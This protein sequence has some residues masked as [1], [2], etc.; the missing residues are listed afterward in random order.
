MEKDKKDKKPAWEP[1][2][3]VEE[4]LAYDAEQKKAGLKK[5]K[6][7]IGNGKYAIRYM[8]AHYKIRSDE[9]EVEI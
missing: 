8:P 4:Q 2:I 3:T 6:S 9:R 7:Y 1:K 5:I